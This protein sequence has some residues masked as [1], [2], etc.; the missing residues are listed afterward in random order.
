MAIRELDG[1]AYIDG[2]EVTRSG[3]ASKPIYVHKNAVGFVMQTGPIKEV[4]VNGVQVDTLIETARI[5]INGLNSKFPC[6][7]NER[8]IYHLEEALRQLKA[9]KRDREARDVEGTSNV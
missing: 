3:E 5:M 8:T 1:L 4:G 2:F 6:I 9:R 7:E